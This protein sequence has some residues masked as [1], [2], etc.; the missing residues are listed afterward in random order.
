MGRWLDSLAGVL[1][2]FS[3]SASCSSNLW[4]TSTASSSTSALLNLLTVVGSSCLNLLIS[5]LR[6][7]LLYFLTTL[8][9]LLTHSLRLSWSGE[10][11]DNLNPSTLHILL[12]LFFNFYLVKFIR[13]SILLLIIRS[14]IHCK[15]ISSLLQ[16]VQLQC[17]PHHFISQSLYFR[18]IR[19]QNFYLV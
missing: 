9:P 6:E 5:L 17:S 3:L 15:A 2:S 13:F 4:I 7:I 19:L 16:S 1:P 18:R 10:R 11:P 8:L 12:S 14:P